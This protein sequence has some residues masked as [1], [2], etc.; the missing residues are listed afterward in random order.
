EVLIAIVVMALG[1][2]GWF[3]V[4]LFL[5][6][7]LVSLQLGWIA[8]RRNS[9]WTAT[10]LRLRHDL[11]EKMV[12]HRT[13]LAQEP[14]DRWHD[15]E[16]PALEKYLGASAAMDRSG[17]LLSALVPHGWMILGVLGLAPA[18]VAAD[19]SQAS[20]AVGLGGMLLASGALQKLS[21]GFSSV[22]GASIAW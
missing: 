10:R 17:T 12:G 11:V 13:R 16:D 4:L 2:G 6:W 9:S 22:A 21:M 7:I 14:A 15:N 5:G 19:H 20:L 18:F 8:Y 1:A 3:Q